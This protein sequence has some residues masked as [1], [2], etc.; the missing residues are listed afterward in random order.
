MKIIVHATIVAFLVFVFSIFMFFQCGPNVT[1][2]T[3]IFV[4]FV[5]SISFHAGYDAGEKN[6]DN[7]NDKER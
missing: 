6:T 4:I 5:S 7:K 2:I 1:V 3:T